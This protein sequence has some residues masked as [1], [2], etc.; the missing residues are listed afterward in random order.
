M[1]SIKVVLL[2]LGTVGKGVY[3]TVITHQEQLQAV[4]GRKVEVVGVLV[5]DK[6][7][8]RGVELDPSILLTSNYKEILDLPNVD[9]VIEMMGGIEPTKQYI[10]QAL[11]KEC[12]VVTANKELMAFHGKELRQI[13]EQANV[14]LAYE[15][16]V[17]GAIPV[18]RTLKELLQVN[19]VVKIEAIINGTTNYILTKMREEHVSFQEA[20]LEAQL[21]GY[22][23][24]DPSNDIEGW[25]AFFKLMVLSDL[26]FDE[27]PNWNLVDRIGIDEVKIEELTIANEFGLRLKLIAS[28][29]KTEK[30]WEAS[31]KPTFVPPSHPLYAVEGV[32]NGIVVETDLAGPLFFQGAG[33]GSLATA[34]A[35]IEDLIN[36]SQRQKSGKLKTGR[37]WKISKQNEK[38]TNWFVVQ[39]KQKLS[40]YIATGEPDNIKHL[41]NQSVKVYPIS[42]KIE[43]K[44]M[45][46][47]KKATAYA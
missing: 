4:L 9:V 17:A 34:S 22:A 43:N 33:A 24:A 18:I 30:G 42:G 29:E 13:A 2:G 23:E 38:S 6:G 46:K 31:V 44:G 10:E 16:S 28:I 40:G 21:K 7:K 14:H 8:Q 47:Q 19:Q 1:E 26:I 36:I 37:K 12:H 5:Q 20:L 35:I 32:N 39:S 25:D 41:L 3:Q 45:D 15:A 27:Q 11:N